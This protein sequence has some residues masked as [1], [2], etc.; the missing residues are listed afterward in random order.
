[1]RRSLGGGLLAPALLAAIVPSAAAAPVEGYD[2]S[3][4]FRCKLQQVG[5]GTDFPDPGAD[6]FCVEYDKRHQNVTQLG[7]V[8]FLSKEPARVA[9][10]SLKCF[11][12]QRDHWRGSVQQD[13]SATETYTWDGGY[14]FDKARGVGGVHVRNFKLAGQTS[15]PRLLPGF[16]DEYRSYFG[17]GRGG[18]QSADGVVKDPRCVEKARRADPYARPGPARPRLHLRVSYRA[19]R[20]PGGRLCVRS[21]LR[22]ALEGPDR[23]AVRTVDFLVDGE[24]VARD[25]HAPFE[26]SIA[27]AHY[28]GRGEFR[29]RARALMN[30]GERFAWGRDLRACASGSGPGFAG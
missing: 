21:D 18:V 27:R 8:D 15:D 2:G 6:P 25:R 13:N 19:G 17:P 23:A 1:M 5:R 9:A 3:N 20:T 22:A 30:G 12:Y 26:R 29:L 16:P 4:P 28:R 10:A 24:R 14:F 7:V 11:Y